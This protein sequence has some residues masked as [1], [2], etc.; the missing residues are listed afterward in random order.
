MGES[1]SGIAEVI[2]ALEAAGKAAQAANFKIV[3][4]GQ[5][6]VEAAAKKS[7][8]G[9]HKKGAPTT[10]TPGSPPDVVTGTLRRSIMSEAPQAVGG[11]GAI[12]RVYP[13]AVYSRIQELGGRGLPARP[14]MQP[15]YDGSLTRLA[16]IATQ[17]WARITH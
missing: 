17:E 6:I 4:R 14:Y 9:Q 7:F 11:D 12:G 13:T 2:A 15:A 5:V 1:I 16:E 10:S 3:T 8:T